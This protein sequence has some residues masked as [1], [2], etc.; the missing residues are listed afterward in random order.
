[1]ARVTA[2]DVGNESIKMVALASRSGM[3]E[4]I[5]VMHEPLDEI[6]RI[7]DGPEKT[8]ALKMRVSKLMALAHLPVSEVVAPVSGRGTIARYVHVPPVPP[9]RL[10][11]LMRFEATQQAGGSVEDPAAESRS[12]DYRMLDVPDVDGQTLLL[13]AI[14]QEATVLE[15]TALARSSGADDPDMDLAALGLFNA[16]ILG[17]GAEE[18][19]APLEPEDDEFGPLVLPGSD[20]HDKGGESDDAKADDGG[21][22]DAEP[23]NAEPDNA[24]PDNAEPDNAEPDN[25]EPD[26]GKTDD[27]K[28]DGDRSADGPGGEPPGPDGEP[29]DPDDD[30]ALPVSDE[31]AP[32]AAAA[33][34]AGP[35]APPSPAGPDNPEHSGAVVL[36][37][38]GADEL[39]LCIVRNGGLYFVRHQPGGGRAFTEAVRQAFW[40]SWLE[41][42]EF[43]RSRGRI[44][45]DPSEAPSEKDRLASEALSRQ[46]SDLAR[47]VEAALMYARAQTKSKTLSIDKVLLSGGGARLEGL[48]A[49]FARR[50]RTEVKPL[51]PL[52]NVS[53]GGLSSNVMAPLEGEYS[54]FAIPIGLALARV[55][56][57]GAT[58]DLRT[59]EDKERRDF[60]R[61]GLFGWAAGFVFALGFAYWI[62]GALR[63]RIIYARASTSAAELVTSDK[64]AMVKL[65]GVRAESRRLEAEM[66]ALR[67]RVTSGED[68]LRVLSQLKRRTPG[69]IR[70][71]SVSTSRPKAIAEDGAQDKDVTFQK[72]RRV[73]VRGYARSR[74]SYPD[75][76]NIVTAYERK[77]AELKDLFAQVLQKV[78]QRVEQ[79]TADTDDE[80]RS[81]RVVEFILEIE[82]GKRR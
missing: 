38:I 9:W 45:A 55:S 27:D 44:Y 67:E 63:D 82:I 3:P 20:G 21:A 15:R 14:S 35:S 65:E 22:N 11:A 24:E 68:L 18:D 66:D 48:P 49:Y 10:E 76:Y 59:R 7:E 23:D 12:F 33:A 79:E 74:Q 80:G 42:E 13:L 70:L 28:G 5:G 1:M 81:V 29:S 37:D 34:S 43:K 4:L 78:A 36:L 32:D 52:R 17:H 26:N 72:S 8:A 75:A 39:N 61:K 31:E 54:T 2:I 77:L 41:A 71:V 40:V 62:A 53:L 25:A 6:G 60:R 19:L 64:S 51:E 73:Y 56:A 30:N 47:T 58:L 50:L 16:Y 46:A 57:K 69:S